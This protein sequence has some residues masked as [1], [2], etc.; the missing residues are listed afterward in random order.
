MYKNL[1]KQLFQI[2]VILL[3]ESVV[4]AEEDM[5]I[6]GVTG[7]RTQP[8]VFLLTPCMFLGHMSILGMATDM[9]V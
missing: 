7:C 3:P 8:I 5:K 9:V 4:G 1:N 6:G 2:N